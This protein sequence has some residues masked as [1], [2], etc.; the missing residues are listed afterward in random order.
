MLKMNEKILLDTHILI[1]SLISP[2][3]LSKETKEIISKAQE[4]D[5]LYIADIT[6]WEIAMLIKKN[7]ISIFMPLRDFLSSITNIDGLNVVSI[8]ASLAADSVTLPD[9]FDGDPADSLI[10]AAT[11]EIAGTLLTRDQRILSYSKQGHIKTLE[12]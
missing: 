6:L 8:S 2:D 9:N 11:R 5:M 10:I 7:R 3:Q 4:N 12:S 1:W